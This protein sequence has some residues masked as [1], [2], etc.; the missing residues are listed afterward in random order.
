MGKTVGVGLMKVF[1][2]LYMHFQIYKM[3]SK[4]FEMSKNELY[5]HK[6]K[7]VFYDMIIYHR[8][9]SLKI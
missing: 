3:A 7:M 1:A 2:F 4:L 5:F 6:I 9:V 8:V